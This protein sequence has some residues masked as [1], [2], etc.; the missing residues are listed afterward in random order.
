MISQADAKKIG[1]IRAT[2]V[3]AVEKAGVK[4]AT[5]KKG[6]NVA[7]NKEEKKVPNKEN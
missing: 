6:T 5:D 3:T 2:V 1:L 4:T 7:A